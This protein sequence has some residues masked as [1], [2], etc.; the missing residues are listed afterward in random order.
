MLLSCVKRIHDKLGYYVGIGIISRVLQGS[1]EKKVLQL[2]LD[3]LSTYGLLKTLGR[4]QIRAMADHLEALG[5]LLTES[6]HQTVR[7]TGTAAQVLYQGQRVE[8][9]VQKEEAP[10]P[11][12]AVTKLTGDESELYDVLRV[13]RGQLAREA[14]IPAYVVFSNATLQDMARKRPGNMTEFKR[15]SGVGEMKANWYGKAFLERIREYLEDR[16]EA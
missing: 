10:T 6:E 2:G 11:P 7:L 5:Y 16:E 15:V 8:M 3:E 13:L 9:L 1:K 4:T 12:A 14:N